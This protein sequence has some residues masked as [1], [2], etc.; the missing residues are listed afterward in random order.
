MEDKLNSRGACTM[1]C[2]ASKMESIR[3]DQCRHV[4]GRLVSHR[5]N[6]HMVISVY[7]S[8][9]CFNLLFSV[10]VQFRRIVVSICFCRCTKVEVQMGKRRAESARRHG[11]GNPRITF[12]I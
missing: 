5:M 6:L 11:F 3:F 12:N 8:L 10:F 1:T 4:F 7:D 9:A 2:R